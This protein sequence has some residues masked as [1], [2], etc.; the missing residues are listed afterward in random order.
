MI[1][2]SI[3]I[4]SAFSNLKTMRISYCQPI[5][6]YGETLGYVCMVIREENKFRLFHAPVLVVEVI[7]SIL[8]YVSC[9]FIYII[10]SMT[11]KMF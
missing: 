10:A 5:P 2:A 4:P 6:N 8:G 3:L 9:I 1:S 7:R 11:D